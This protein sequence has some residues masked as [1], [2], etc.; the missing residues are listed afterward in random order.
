MLHYS[1]SFINHYIDQNVD[2]IGLKNY[3]LTGASSAQPVNSALADDIAALKSTVAALKSQL[4]GT[5]I[6]LF[7]AVFICYQPIQ[8]RIFFTHVI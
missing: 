7:I 3:L 8:S 6:N 4:T 5:K 1:N 2:L